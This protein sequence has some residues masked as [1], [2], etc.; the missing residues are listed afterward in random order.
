M[1]KNE[2]L[3]NQLGIIVTQK[4]YAKYGHIDVYSRTTLELSPSRSLFNTVS[5]F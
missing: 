5:W 2:K 1:R 3:V 4:S